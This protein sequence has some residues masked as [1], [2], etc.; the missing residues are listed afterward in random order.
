MIAAGQKLKKASSSVFQ[1]IEE[2]E[3]PKPL[4]WRK[5]FQHVYFDLADIEI[6]VGHS[7]NEVSPDYMSIFTKANGAK[8]N[9]AQ[10]EREVFDTVSPKCESRS[11]LSGTGRSEDKLHVATGPESFRDPED[12]IFTITKPELPP[13]IKLVSDRYLPKTSETYPKGAYGGLA[14]WSDERH[15]SEDR[16]YIE[17]RVSE[18][19]LDEVIETI[20]LHP[21]AL[22]KVGIALQCFSY[23]VDD[24]FREPWMRRDLI[25]NASATA[26][27]CFIGTTV[28]YPTK[29]EGK[30]DDDANISADSDLAE[31]SQTPRIQEPTPHPLFA[32]AAEGVSKLNK[33]LWFIGIVLALHLFK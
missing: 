29:I 13:S 20:R 19:Q 15:F 17:C 18:E 7:V 16:I 33:P 31:M 6:E 23:E 30:D 25:V 26:L 3:K 27:C 4:E 2:P 1:E 22:I 5:S 24:F 28:K 12:G 21:G 9:E 8:E 32:A 11:A 10:P 14:Y